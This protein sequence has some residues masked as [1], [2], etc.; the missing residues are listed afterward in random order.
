ML[1][2]G[3]FRVDAS[4]LTGLRQRGER[5]ELRARLPWT[6][7]PGLLLLP[8]ASRLTWDHHDDPEGG[9]PVHLLGL[10]ARPAQ[11]CDGEVDVCVRLEFGRPGPPPP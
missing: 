5:L 1:T 7:L 3:D 10:L 2:L 11:R 6:E 4:E 8:Q 9:L